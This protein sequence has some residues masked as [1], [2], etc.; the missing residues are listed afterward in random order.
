M[1]VTRQ[2]R[3]RI[4]TKPPKSPPRSPERVE[5]GSDGFREQRPP[6]SGL[7]D[8]RGPRMLCPVAQDTKGPLEE[9][10]H[11]VKALT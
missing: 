2:L 9:R 4:E 1:P 6:P 10:R 8:K 11:D 5:S 3:L 7:V